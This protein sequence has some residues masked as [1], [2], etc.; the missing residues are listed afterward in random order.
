MKDETLITNICTHMHH[1][2]PPVTEHSDYVDP[3]GN[4]EGAFTR[5][6]TKAECAYYLINSDYETY[7]MYCD[8][9][10]AYQEERAATM[11][12]LSARKKL[13]KANYAYTIKKMKV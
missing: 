6:M 9:W 5:S 2:F 12:L 3:E 4:Q 10:K 8:L 1:K 13:I 11:R 7:Q